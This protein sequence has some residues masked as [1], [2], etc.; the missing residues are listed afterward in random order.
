MRKVFQTIMFLLLLTALICCKDNNSPDN[1]SNSGGTL[2]ITAASGTTKTFLP[3]VEL[4]KGVNVFSYDVL[5]LTNVP[6]WFR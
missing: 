3:D 1:G 4:L 2:K 6:K 5:I